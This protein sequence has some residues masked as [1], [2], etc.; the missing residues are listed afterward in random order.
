MGPI[1]ELDGAQKMSRKMKTPGNWKI[2][3]I[4]SKL[5]KLM[6]FLIFKCSNGIVKIT[7]SLY[8]LYK[9]YNICI[10]DLKISNNIY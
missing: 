3:S 2:K 1:K 6:K 9:R 8:P 7:K 5:Y 4:C 10:C